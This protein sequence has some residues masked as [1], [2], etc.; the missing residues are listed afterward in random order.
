[1]SIRNGF[2]ISEI[3]IPANDTALQSEA[4]AAEPPAPSADAE[5]WKALSRENEKRWKQTAAELDR[6]RQAQMTEQE[7]VLAQA[8]H[9]ARQ[10]A[11][12]ELGTTLAEAEIRAQAA[13]AGVS[14]P[15]DYLDLSRFLGDDGRADPEK[16]SAF[17]S[18]LPKPTHPQPE[19]PQLV[20]TGHHRAGDAPVTTLDPNE[21]ADII[22][23]GAHI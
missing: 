4:P 5:R 12:S 19:F 15:T 22:T 10:D 18:S 14:A 8:R 2:T 7:K 20:G 11:L 1:M 3:E 17:I 23:G 13:S 6:L 21:L 9:E 16:V